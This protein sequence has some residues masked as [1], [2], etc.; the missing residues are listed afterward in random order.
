MFAIYCVLRAKFSH[1]VNE[2]VIT[3]IFTAEFDRTLVS[4]IL[5]ILSRWEIEKKIPKSLM[6][7]RNHYYSWSQFNAWLLTFNVNWFYFTIWAQNMNEK[8]ITTFAISNLVF[9][10]KID[11]INF[12]KVWLTTLKK[13]VMIVN[14]THQQKRFSLTSQ[15]DLF[16]H[17]EVNASNWFSDNLAFRESR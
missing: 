11:F 15:I 2:F 17:F 3:V 1:F 8:L 5:I 12:A 7:P 14:I 9:S 6:R 13:M 16:W 10:Y 4:I